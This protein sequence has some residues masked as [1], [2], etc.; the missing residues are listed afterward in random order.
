MNLIERVKNILRQPKTEWQTISTEATSAGD[1]YKNY[2]VPLAA[3]GP[4]ASIIGMSVVGISLPFMGGTFRVPITSSIAQA[5]T[6]YVLTLVGVFV[7]ALIIDALAPS[8]GGEKNQIQALKTATYAS[9]P[10]W[11]AGG[12]MILPMLG[13]IV[14]L[15][16]LYGLYLLYLGLPILMKAPQEKAVGYT[17]VVVVVAIVVMMVIGAVSGIFMPTPT[18]PVP[19]FTPH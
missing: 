11:V 10:S 12:L 13:P 17:A 7:I 6:S 1:L 2:I 14:M 19:N 16:A 9:T 18:M 3:I 15:V 4:A 8:F 5:V